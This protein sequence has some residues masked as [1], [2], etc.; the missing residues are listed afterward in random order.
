MIPRTPPSFAASFLLVAAVG[1]LSGC[2]ATAANYSVAADA[3]VALRAAREAHAA[4]LS[5]GQVQMVGEASGEQESLGCRAL[6]VAAPADRGSF[7]EYVRRALID[8]LNVAGLYDPKSPIVVRVTIS[9]LEITSMGDS[10]IDGV[11]RF[12]VGSAADENPA[13][14]VVKVPFTSAFVADTACRNAATAF[15]AAVQQA[16][17]SF[18]RSPEFYRATSPSKPPAG[19]AQGRAPRAPSVASPTP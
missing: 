17:V 5:V 6:S 9:R 10:T 3:Q 2:G 14:H 18:V 16:I 13:T 12:T 11:F 4:P 7:P 19:A 15:P 8:E 1:L